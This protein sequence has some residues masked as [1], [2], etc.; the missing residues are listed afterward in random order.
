MYATQTV[1][2]FQQDGVQLELTVST[3]VAGSISLFICFFLWFKWF[4]SQ[5]TSDR[6]PLY[7]M[8]YLTYKVSTIDNKSHSVR[9]Y[10]DNTAEVSVCIC[11]GGVHGGV[12]SM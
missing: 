1:Y 9:L 5:F 11:D 6:L 2:V 10:Y 7:S 8:A 4:F 3:C 12:V